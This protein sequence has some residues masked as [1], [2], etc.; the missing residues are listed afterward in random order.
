M[1]YASPGPEYAHVLAGIAITH[2]YQ[3]FTFF[4]QA[5]TYFLD[6][7]VSTFDHKLGASSP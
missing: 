5:G 1:D 7:K 6:V 2:H 4:N 3:R